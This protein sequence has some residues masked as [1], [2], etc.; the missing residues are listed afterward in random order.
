MVIG[1][2]AIV[3]AYFVRGSFTAYVQ[4]RRLANRGGRGL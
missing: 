3:S 4:R 2:L 1:C